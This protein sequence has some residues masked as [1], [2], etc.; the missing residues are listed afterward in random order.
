[1][2][3]Y[4]KI[5][6]VDISEGLGR[7]DDNSIDLVITSPPY[8]VGIDYDVWD[9]K[10]NPVA[11]FEWVSSWMNELYRVM[12]VSGRLAINIPYEVNFKSVQGGRSLILSH[13]HMIMLSAGFKFAG[14]ADLVEDS[15]QMVKRTAWGSWLSPSAPYIYNPKECVIIGYKDEWKKATKGV[16]YFTD[17]QESKKEFMDLVIGQWKYKAETRGLTK[18]NFSLDVPEKALKI[19]SWD[20]DIVLDPFMGSGTTALAC[21]KLGRTYIGFEISPAYHA[22]AEKRLHDFGG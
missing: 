17:D 1:M 9:D 18:A 15:P 22:I 6:N 12:K 10:M 13:Y 14:I 5:Y 21:K 4:N 16:S 8:N 7:L 11:Y 20:T 3:E 19:L 2:L